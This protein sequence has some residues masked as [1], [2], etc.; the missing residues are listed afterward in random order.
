[1]IV[2]V[3][4]WSSEKVAPAP[5]A[6]TLPLKLREALSVTEI[7]KDCASIGSLELQ[8]VGTGG[9]SENAAA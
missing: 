3:P 9:N 5:A 8:P 1:V 4:D 2:P 7:V 6:V